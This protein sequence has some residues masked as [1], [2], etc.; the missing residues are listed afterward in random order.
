MLSFVKGV[1]KI[2]WPLGV[3]AV[4]LIGFFSFA[5]LGVVYAT[6]SESAS[7]WAWGGGVTNNPPG[8]EGMGWISFNDTDAAN[9]G[10]FYGVN[11][12]STGALSGHAWSEYYGWISFNGSDLAGCVPALTQATRTGNNIS[13]GARILAIRDAVMAGNA[14]DYDGC[15]DLSGVS[16]DG[17]GSAATLTGYAWSSDLGW[18]QMSGSGFGVV[19]NN[20]SLVFTANGGT[21]VSVDANDPV[22]FEW[23]VT[24]MNSCVASGDWSGA[25]AFADGTHVETV[26]PTTAVTNYTLTCIDDNGLSLAETVTVTVNPPSITFTSNPP[27]IGPGDS[28]DLDWTVTGATGCSI[29]ASMEIAG[30]WEN[31]V[32]LSD[33]RTVT[34][35]YA[36][37]TTYTL[38]CTGIGGTTPSSVTVTMPS[39]YLT[40]TSC[41]I[42]VGGSSC[43]SRVEWGASDFLG[44]PSVLQDGS[45]FSAANTGDQMMAVDPSNSTFRLE[46]DGSSFFIET[47]PTVG[48]AAGSVWVDALTT[49]MAVPVVSVVPTPNFVRQGQTAAIDVTVTAGYDTQCA[50]TDGG[51]VPSTFAHTFPPNTATYPQATRSLSST[52][53]VTV[54]CW[55]T[56]YPNV[57]GVGQA[58]VEVIPAVEEI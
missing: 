56:T 31:P 45:A 2:S 3:K 11:V 9:A 27:L 13:G 47:T 20:P 30:Q 54:E 46:D 41:T 32:S 26:T 34:P 15:I 1:P 23:I 40:A 10:G 4:F 18:I 14:G 29:P 8:Y 51:S 39:G 16:V 49:C 24:G 6:S 21:S 22:T 37:V 19:L 48:C 38:E 35:S 7:G 50:M 36:P 33:M 43:M 12:P 28:S 44:A 17:V 57:R 52:Q 5:I 58:R 55:H 53:I 25:K 42:P